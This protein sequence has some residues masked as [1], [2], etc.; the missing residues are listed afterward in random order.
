MKKKD[1]YLKKG[2]LLLIE[3]RY[4]IIER[5]YKVFFKSK[6]KI[7]EIIVVDEREVE[8]LSQACGLKI[9]DY[10]LD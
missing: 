10:G 7:Q 1:E 3:L 6:G 5:R 4:D 8:G 9:E 2:R